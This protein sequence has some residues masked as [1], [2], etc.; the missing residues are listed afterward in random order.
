MLDFASLAL[1]ACVPS[2]S[3]TI[4]PLILTSLCVSSAASCQF[5]RW[6]HRDSKTLRILPKVSQLVC[7]GATA[8]PQTGSMAPNQGSQPTERNP[9]HSSPASACHAELL[10]IPFNA[11][12]PKRQL[13]PWAEEGDPLF[14]ISTEFS[15]GLVL[16]EASLKWNESIPKGMF[17]CITK[18]RM[19]T[20][21]F[22]PYQP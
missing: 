5:F 21:V 6:R 8:S 16:V 14:L 1:P 4:Q 7:V 2:T 20:E 12:N 19:A 22:L 3:Y 17:T 13:L 11:I 15:N 18:A 10:K 9:L